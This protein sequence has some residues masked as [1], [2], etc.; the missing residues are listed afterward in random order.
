M[1]LLIIAFNLKVNSVNASEEN[2]SIEKNVES[3]EEEKDGEKERKNYYEI[4]FIKGGEYFN[5]GA[6]ISNIVWQDY[7]KFERIVI[8]INELNF[9]SEGYKIGAPYKVPCPFMINYERYPIR[10]YC[11][12]DAGQMLIDDV[13][14]IN[15]NDSKV[16]RSIYNIP[17]MES[18]TSSFGIDFKKPI[19]YEVFELRNPARIVID[20]K[21][22]NENM[23]FSNIYSLRSK[24]SEEIENLSFIEES[25]MNIN[26][27]N[28]RI[29][30][31]K[32]DNL[33]VEEGYYEKQEDAEKRRAEISSQ[34][35]E[36][37]IKLFIE[38]RTDLSIPNGELKND[39]LK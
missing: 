32:D 5:D 3:V 11:K 23:I 31:S 21:E 22:N 33:F 6:I 30:Q 8:N 34:L 15:L 35:S 13:E 26:S 24:S 10:M 12:V 17:Y 38:K 25:L 2:I 19:K 36:Y 18:G 27:T 28:V 37:N 9:D 4:D 16:I 14:N 39:L 1:V 20:I 29:L 7:G